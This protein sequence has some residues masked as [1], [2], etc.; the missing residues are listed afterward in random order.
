MPDEPTLF[1]DPAYPRDLYGG[2]PPSEPVGTSMEA[3]RRIAVPSATLRAEVLRTVRAA[4]SDGATDDEIERRTG[5]RHQTASAR[6]RELVLQGFLRDSGRTR[7]T[8]SG[9]SAKVWVTT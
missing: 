2:R 9:R 8:S 3:A 5:L 4:G 7:A 1:D 6:R